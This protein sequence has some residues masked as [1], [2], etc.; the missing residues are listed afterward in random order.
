M[1]RGG[2][3][4]ITEKQKS[5][6]DNEPKATDLIIVEYTA[7]REEILKRV[8][9]QHQILSLTLIIFGTILSF[10][11]QVHSSSILLLYAI[12]AL[13]LAANWSHNGRTVR[14]IG[15]YI[16]SQIETKVGVQNI[17]WEHR[18]RP[19]QRL[20]GLNFISARGIFIGT[21]LLAIVL[22][23][24]LAKFDLEDIFLFIVALSS[25]AGSTLIL[26]RN[27]RAKSDLVAP[28]AEKTN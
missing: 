24:P 18:I 9:L 13:F 2:G 11:L 26:R 1:L 21:S 14:D 28:Q 10:G 3:I 17:G 15:R 8:E 27:S 4:L 20:G 5:S 25:V 19:R 22:A 23:I 12:I 7:L 16:R 6:S